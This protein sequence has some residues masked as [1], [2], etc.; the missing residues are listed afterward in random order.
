MKYLLLMLF[1]LVGC[2]DKTVKRDT[3]P[4]AKAGECYEY[5]MPHNP[6]VSNRILNKISHIIVT[7]TGSTYHYE[8]VS[9]L[10]GSYDNGGESLTIKK[11]SRSFDMFREHYQKRVSCRLEFEPF[12][13]SVYN[14]LKIKELTDKTEK[15]VKFINGREKMRYECNNLL[16]EFGLRLLSGRVFIDLDDNNNPHCHFGKHIGSV[17]EIREKLKAELKKVTK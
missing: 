7:E 10:S 4:I 17:E 6:S 2:S 1:M 5:F 14:E 11:D 9:R 3:L 8:Y 15:L 13:E 12:R 16:N